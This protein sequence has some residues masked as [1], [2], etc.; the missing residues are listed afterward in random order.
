MLGGR[1]EGTQQLLFVCFQ[2][3]GLCRGIWS[4]PLNLYVLT[5]SIEVLFRKTIQWKPNQRLQ[6]YGSPELDM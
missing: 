4:Q 3:M 5:N 1:L 6:S 2:Q